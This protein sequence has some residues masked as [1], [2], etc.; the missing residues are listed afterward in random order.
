M[1]I[2]FL[3]KFFINYYIYIISYKTVFVNKFYRI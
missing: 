3:L 2:I 1:F